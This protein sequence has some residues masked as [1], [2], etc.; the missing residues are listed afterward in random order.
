M[1]AK[2]QTLRILFFE[3]WNG[4]EICALAFDVFKLSPLEG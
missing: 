3:L 4:F 1:K 2:V